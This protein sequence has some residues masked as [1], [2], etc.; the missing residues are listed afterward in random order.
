MTRHDASL[1]QP[2]TKYV[3]P[4]KQE[5]RLDFFLALGVWGLCVLAGLWWLAVASA[6]Q[7]VPHV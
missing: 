1:V 6:S 5:T 2:R 3:R 7:A 4:E